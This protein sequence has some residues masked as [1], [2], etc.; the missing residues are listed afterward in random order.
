[1]PAYPSARSSPVTKTDDWKQERLREEQSK[2]H[3]GEGYGS[4][5][6][7]QVWEVWNWD[8]RKMADVKAKDEKVVRQ[9]R[10]AAEKDERLQ[11][12]EDEFPRKG[13]T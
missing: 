6:M 1:M 7:D 11:R 9:V 8:K 13:K 5:M 3:S 10:E 12:T 2:L 4:M